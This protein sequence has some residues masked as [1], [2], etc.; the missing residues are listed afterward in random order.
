MLVMVSCSK[1]DLFWVCDR[2]GYFR[3]ESRVNL[4]VFRQ[5]RQ[6]F[7]GFQ[8]SETTADEANTLEIK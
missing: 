7:G 5:V 4:P 1:I 8:R 6:A 2:H 3:R